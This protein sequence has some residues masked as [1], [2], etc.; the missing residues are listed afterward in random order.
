M[1]RQIPVLA[2]LLATVAAPLGAQEASIAEIRPFVS[3][4]VPAQSQRGMFRDAPM[5]GVQAALEL[6]PSFHAVSSFAWAPARTGYALGADRV[7]I[8]QYDV[9]VT[10]GLVR[11]M[12]DG[13]EL[14]PFLGAGAG[15][16]SYLYEAATL[17]NRPLSSA[18]YAAAG[19]EFQLG[20]TALRLEMRN[21]IYNFEPP[22]PDQ[23]PVLRNDFTFSLG[24]A[25]HLR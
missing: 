5:F 21:Y 8:L 19:T 9:G 13:W 18:A 14:R 10:L 20:H 15:G 24:M 11:P 17:T 4:Y 7:H 22:F 16:R 6:L 12:G 25:F 1:T 2:I 23:E 3:A